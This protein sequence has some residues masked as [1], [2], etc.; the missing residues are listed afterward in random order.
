MCGSKAR[1]TGRMPPRSSWMPRTCTTCPISRSVSMTSYSIFHSASRMSTPVVS[2]G[3]TRWSCTSA[4]MRTFF[5]SQEQAMPAAV[6]V[7]HRL[8]GQ[9]DC[10]LLARLILGTDETELELA[11]PGDHVL[12]HLID[13]VLIDAGPARDDAADRAPDARD[14]SRCRDVV[15]KLR[16]VGEHLP[17]VAIVEVRVVD[18]VVAPLVA[19]M[20]PQRQLQRRQRID[21]LGIV[22]P[23]RLAAQ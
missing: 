22:D 2:S 20:L 10:E 7:I 13:R 6:K 4:R 15:R 8:Y 12:E 18:A 19:V 14:E 5:T 23:R 9:Q 3:G 16:C 17:Q 21:F 11:A 1:T